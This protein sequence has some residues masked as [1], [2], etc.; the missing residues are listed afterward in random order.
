MRFGVCRHWLPVWLPQGERSVENIP[1]NCAPSAIRTRDLLLRRHS[2]DVARRRRVWPDVAFSCTDSGWTWLGVAQYLPLLAPVWLPR[3]SLASLTF[4]PIELSIDPRPISQLS[5]MGRSGR[6]R[7]YPPIG[8][9]AGALVF[10][11]LR[12]RNW[13]IWN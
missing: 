9:A 4:G 8:A 3:I 10:R 12:E 6:T 5:V 11:P 2:P 7:T 1:V 13:V